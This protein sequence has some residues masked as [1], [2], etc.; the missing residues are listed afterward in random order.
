MWIFNTFGLRRVAVETMNWIIPDLIPTI[1]CVVA[2]RCSRGGRRRTGLSDFRSEVE[3]IKGWPRGYILSQSSPIP[4]GATTMISV[5][6]VACL[7]ISSQ[8][9]HPGKSPISLTFHLAPSHTPPK[10]PLGWPLFALSEIMRRFKYKT[11]VKFCQPR[12]LARC[13]SRWQLWRN[14]NTSGSLW[15]E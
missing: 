1:T 12:P 2:S 6:K 11:S 13:S 10:G 8:I 4:T 3:G 7:I 9:N 5:K 15:L 14:G